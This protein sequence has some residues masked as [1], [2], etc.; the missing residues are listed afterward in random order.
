M[1]TARPSGSSAPRP[2]EKHC[3]GKFGHLEELLETRF[4]EEYI[5]TFVPSND[6]TK[7]SLASISKAK[8]I[9][10]T[11]R[12]TPA[13]HILLLLEFQ[14]FQPK[15]LVFSNIAKHK[16]DNGN[17]K[18]ARFYVAVLFSPISEQ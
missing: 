4:T 9:V 8:P 1:I 3:D 18:I 7:I 16:H 5:I 11:E 13:F 6:G 15:L 2:K 10:I 17:G 14:N 12:W